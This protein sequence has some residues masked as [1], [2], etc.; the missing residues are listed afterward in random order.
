MPSLYTSLLAHAKGARTLAPKEQRAPVPKETESPSPQEYAKHISN[1]YAG[2]LDE[3]VA[4]GPPTRSIAVVGTGIP[5]RCTGT[6]NRQVGR[7]ARHGSTGT[8]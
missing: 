1:H 6:W 7:S 4:L 8:L 5:T 3:L 2:V